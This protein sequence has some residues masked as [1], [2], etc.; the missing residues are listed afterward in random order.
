MIKTNDVIGPEKSELTFFNDKSEL[1]RINL[2]FFSDAADEGA[3]DGSEHEGEGGEDAGADGGQDDETPS[4]LEELFEK[5]PH[6]KE[7]HEKDKKAAVKKAV[8]KRFKDNKQDNPP[9]KEEAGDSDELQTLKEQINQQ[10]ALIQKAQEK[11]NRASIKEFAL[12]NGYDSQLSAALIRP[13]DVELD[14]DGEPSNL[15]ELF[16]EVAQRFPKYFGSQDDEDVERRS[17]SNKRTNSYVPGSATKRGNKAA[18]VDPFELGKQR[19]LAR[20]KKEDK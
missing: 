13:S 16:E 2:Q 11:Q 10:N 15:A 17:D 20:H 3:G 9:K 12:D 5:F 1:L 8:Q 7:Q 4:S 19:A 18:K 14:E 6:L